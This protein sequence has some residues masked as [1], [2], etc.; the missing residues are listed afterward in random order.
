MALF[1]SA[2]D[3]HTIVD[4]KEAAACAGLRHVSDGRPGIRRRK[5]GKGF[6]YTRPDGSRVTEADVLRR[7]KPLAIPPAWTDVWICP[8]ADGHIQA[9]GRDAKGAQAIPLS[10]ALSRGPR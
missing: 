4:P 8:S 3:V 6:T 2:A 7:I 1:E 10:R 9:T 5:S